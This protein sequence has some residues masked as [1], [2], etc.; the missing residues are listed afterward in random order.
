MAEEEIEVE[1]EREV[2]VASGGT[3]ERWLRISRRPDDPAQCWVRAVGTTRCA[4][5]AVY[6]T[7][8]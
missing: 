1:E 7:P 2:L 5:H 4:F 8:I 6:F 3:M